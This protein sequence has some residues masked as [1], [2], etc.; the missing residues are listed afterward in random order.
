MDG[1]KRRDFY[2][3]RMDAVASDHHIVIDSTLKQDTSIVNDLSAYSH[4]ARIKVC[5]DVSVLYAYDLEKK[6][7]ICAEVFPCKFIDATSYPAFIEHN[8][9]TR[10][11]IVADKGFPPSKIAHQLEMHPGLHFLTPIRRNDSRIAANGMLSWQGVLRGIDRRVAYC[12]KRIK[13]GALVVCI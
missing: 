7:P 8:N 2:I 9:I 11:I 1:A 12:R 6:E 10:G 5:A 13:G 4:K 3:R